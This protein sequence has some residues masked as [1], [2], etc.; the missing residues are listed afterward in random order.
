M[1]PLDDSASTYLE[2]RM[3]LLL[4][5]AVSL[6]L[7]W[8]LLPFYGTLLWA[9]IIAMMFSPVHRWLL[10][11]LKHRRSLAALLTLLIVLLLFILP[12]ALITAALASEAMALFERLQSGELKPERYFRGVFDALPDWV[13][14][15]L[16][17]FGLVNFTTLL[18]R[19]SAALGQGGDYF[20]TQALG[21]GQDTFEF[22]AALFVT[23]YLAFFL[24]RDGE[25]MA[26]AI[27]RAIPLMP[28]HKRELFATF[29]TVI[30]ATVRGN[31]MVAAVQGAL[32]GLAF[33]FLGVGGAVLWA[34]LM[35]FASLVPAV[36]AALVWV[37]V[38]VYF[39]VSGAIWQCVALTAWGMLVI[40]L[41][42]NLLRPMLVGKD[43]HMPDYVVMIST[44]GGLAVFG[45][46]GF[47]L[48][49]AIAAMF[50][51]VWH[52]YL[53]TQAHVPP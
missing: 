21:F 43:T 14:S 32:G 9:S 25:R 34:V 15:L 5:V 24:I 19:L 10:S 28:E 40:G 3:L 27:R 52:L 26:H 17:R 41:I 1:K 13:A 36:G 45:I 6:A 23:L 51:A 49:P 44:L 29:G 50:F 30:R 39:L 7:G 46:N 31:L 16:D 38:A 18:R 35:A 42:D 37:P 4:L 33:W 11:R 22:T 47:V 53:A 8:I 48:G 2:R 12:L 20:A